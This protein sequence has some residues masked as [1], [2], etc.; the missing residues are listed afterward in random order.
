MHQIRVKVG[1]AKT[2]DKLIKRRYKLYFAHQNRDNFEEGL[3]NVLIKA[4]ISPED[5]ITE[6][7]YVP[8]TPKYAD[9]AIS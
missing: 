9:F 8:E 3:A 7:D 2:R 6:A 5:I 1:W 4:G